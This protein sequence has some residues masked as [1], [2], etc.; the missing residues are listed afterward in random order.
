MKFSKNYLFIFIFLSSI[1]LSTYFFDIYIKKYNIQKDFEVY[2]GESLYKVLD[3]LSIDINLYNKIYF[4]LSS[5]ENLK[6]EAGNYKI[7]G[8][9]SFF[10]LMKELKKGQDDIVVITIPEGYTINKIA[11]ELDQKGVVKRSVFEES[12]MTIDVDDF[13]YPVP[14]NNFE[15]YFFPD[16]YYFVKN[17]TAEDVIRKFLNRF[18]EKYPPSRY[19]DS[20]EFY[21]NLILASII[22][23]EAGNNEEMDI[24]SS[25]FRN[26]M[27]KGMKLQSC[28]TV[29]YLF[30]YE[31]G[32]ISY[33]DLKIDSVYNTYLNRGLPP[34]P[35]SNPGERAVK[36]S[37]EPVDTDYYYFVLQ[38]N[39]R[40]Y[41]SKT[42]ED[43]IKVQNK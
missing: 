18:L 29:A 15:G 16:T 4:K 25:V 31:K 41:F 14:N 13:Y 39:G 11:E 2:K 40:H 17:E 6:V 35:I 28:A 8:R 24:I 27:R 9:Y 38:K 26:R 21:K 1:F 10:V 32:H 12:L 33:K 42:Y 20:D 36:A 7:H 5:K 19:P 22:E 37:Y 30:D 34:N 3:R 23:K 43:H